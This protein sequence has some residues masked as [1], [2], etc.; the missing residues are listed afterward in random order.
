MNE[1]LNS[2]EKLSELYSHYCAAHAS[3]NLEE[4]YTDYALDQTARDFYRIVAVSI[5][6]QDARNGFRRDFAQ[7]VNALT[8]AVLIP[9]SD[10]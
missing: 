5:G 9:A 7:F 2:P 1:T 8:S 6:A 3:V 10:P 4:T